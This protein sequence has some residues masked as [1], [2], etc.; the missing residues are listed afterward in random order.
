MVDETVWYYLR[1]SDSVGPAPARQLLDLL[2]DGRVHH[3]TLVWREGLAEWQTLEDAFGL[4][5]LGP[6]PV[7]GMTP[8][9]IAQ[10]GA[11]PGVAA[12]DPVPRHDLRPMRV[13][14]DSV[15]A[16]RSTAGDRFD[17][18][19]HPWR[20]YFARSIDTMIGAFA[21]SAAL[22]AIWVS[23]DQNGLDTFLRSLHVPGVQLLG[24]IL[25][26]ALATI[27]NA[28]L[29]G[30]TGGSVG[31]WVF[32]ITVAD[33]T[34]RPIGVI[35]AFSRELRI[36]LQGYGLGIPVVALITLIVSYRR[37]SD[38]GITAWDQDLS[39]GVRYRPDGM[40]QT[41]CDLV[42]G[43]LWLGLLIFQIVEAGRG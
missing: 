34:G 7:P 13:S 9:A 24:N 12:A 22:G 26:L 8:P 40:L 6:P 19:P 16:A 4:S 33:A 15:G 41:L 21:M 11:A 28:L 38:Q 3:E 29:I 36:W 10:P 43:A 23:I 25:V 39:L 1:G 42:G 5:D 18:E 31:K 27:P 35:R 20:R 37:L 14:L 2:H 32:G 30:L 17:A